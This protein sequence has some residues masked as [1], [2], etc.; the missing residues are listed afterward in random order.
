[1]GIARETKMG[2]TVRGACEM[3]TPSRKPSGQSRVEK[4]PVHADVGSQAHSNSY[5]KT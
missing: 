2:S 1:M 5:R 3:S 4:E